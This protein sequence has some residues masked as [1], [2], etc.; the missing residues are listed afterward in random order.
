MANQAG[1]KRRRSDEPKLY[2]VHIG[3]N[4][5]VYHTY[6]EC[7]AQARGVKNAAFKAFKTYQEAQEFVEHGLTTSS[8]GPRKFYAVRVGRQPG[9]YTDW[10]STQ[11]QVTGVKG[12]KFKS[13]LT[14]KQAE[15]YMRGAQVN[16][17][18]IVKSTTKDRK[19][20]VQAPD[21]NEVDET[22]EPGYG[23]LPSGAE[24]GF[25]R[26][27]KLNQNTGAVEYKSDGELR[28]V[29]MQATGLA[30]DQPLRIYTD[31][32]A[33]KNGANGARAGVGVYF[34]PLDQRNVSEP[35]KGPRQ[36]NQ[37]AELTACRRAVDIAPR[38][39]DVIIYTDSKYSISCV[40]EWFVNWRK[41]NWMTKDHRPVENKDLIEP[42]LQRIE[43]R[44][45]LRADT[46]FE[47][48]KG[49]ANDEG[50]VAA[51]HL[52]VNGARE[53]AFMDPDT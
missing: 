45:L 51:D 5:G 40:T 21:A 38:D 44:R 18:S 22:I 33:L 8:S 7:L 3:K 11:A 28:A 36:T 52:A 16:G 24:D 43:E 32:S 17:H 50:N 34:G 20:V 35:L 49:H 2:A 31:G 26:R 37:R 10:P 41:N 47:W 29:K 6:A 4:P 46:R 27:L 1:S 23:P 25:D 30:R 42:I 39:R 15:E 19:N 9:I 12:P 14:R 13:F 48:V 53:G